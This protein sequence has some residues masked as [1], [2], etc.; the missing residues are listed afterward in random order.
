MPALRPYHYNGTATTTPTRVDLRKGPSQRF[1]I[2]NT[3]A[4]NA[5]QISFDGGRTFFSIAPG[6]TLREDILCHFF[7]IQSGAATTTYTALVMGS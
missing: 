4:T 1:V 7:F 2:T 6:A 5:L 3:G